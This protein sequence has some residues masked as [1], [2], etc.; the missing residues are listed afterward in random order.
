MIC[1]KNF[2]FL[3]RSQIALTARRRRAKRFGMED[4]MTYEETTEKIIK[5]LK[6]YKDFFSTEYFLDFERKATN[7]KENIEESLKEGR[8][9]KIGIVG[10][11][12]AGK[13]SFL[14]SMI[15]DGE[16]ILPK[17][18]TPMTAALT[19]IYYADK[20]TAKIVFY[21][22]KD[23]ERVKSYSDE[24]LKI[25][26]EEYE[27]YREDL[28][29]KKPD[30][31]PVTKQQYKNNCEMIPDQYKS[32]NELV[33]MAK[34]SNIMIE[35]W[36]GK[37]KEVDC[38]N[39]S[40]ELDDYIG[41]DG[42]YTAIVKYV[43][44]G[45]DNDALKGL[46]IVDTPGMNDP[47]ISRGE[48]TRQFLQKCDV[49]F[50]LSYT[51]QF[52]TQ[53]DINFM[54]ETLPREGVN[55]LLIVGSKLD[56]GVIDNSKD[57]DFITA[58]RKS[59]KIYNSQAEAHIEKSIRNEYN[60]EIL[61]K[62]KE[63]LPPSYVSSLVYDVAR[64]RSKGI[65][66]SKNEQRII[67]LFKKRFDGFSEEERFLLSFSGIPQ[68]R[69]K[70]LGEI[71]KHKDQ[72]IEE[73]NSDIV[74][75]SRKQLCGIIEQIKNEVDTNY[76]KLEN[77][78]INQL[79]R[80]LQS[81]KSALSD[82]R[83]YIENVFE[84]Y[85][86][87]AKKILNNMKVDI[88]QE[89]GNYREFNIKRE[90]EQDYD[91][92]KTGFIFKKKQ[93]IQTSRTV[94]SANITDVIQNLRNYII[95]CKKLVNETFDKAVNINQLK[96]DIKDVIFNV[97]EKTGKDFNEADVLI[98]LDIVLGRILIPKLEIEV[99]EYEGMIIDS[100]SGTSVSGEKVEQL[101]RQEDRVLDQISGNIKRQ[102]DEC[103]SK[104]CDIMKEQSTVFVDNV[105]KTL[106]ENIN[107]LKRQLSDRKNN[108][109]RYRELQD[110]LLEYYTE[111][112]KM[113]I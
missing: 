67:D 33:E 87:D 2:S 113:E 77:G 58:V 47:I 52:L 3:E 51:G 46:E 26:D 70:K 106:E 92:V 43:E 66:L 21:N 102:I 45:M 4:F 6:Q 28:K 35:E 91:V 12:K 86:V 62:I 25:L 90:V 42:N 98:T 44:L 110:Y 50:L 83:R 96:R 63:S 97:F 48:I 59:K 108:L 38:S 61:Q 24:C 13:S 75:N 81:I 95:R 17:A 68:V 69:V 79:E 39:F 11:M 103:E 37:E 72:W 31:S 40:D 34:K 8:L 93:V 56:S 85:M 32:C 49:V 104:V 1:K 99:T 54:T 36:L 14:N 20:N 7:L 60:G 10:E 82:M 64:K 101:K 100:F 29:E 74:K 94:Y 107:L 71:R 27:K 30:M 109:C 111:I 15:F 65:S 112:D 18:S 88:D 9:L 76:S 105:V 23:W 80:Q 73:K 57:K 19:K 5:G 89:I 22:E 78:D 55:N 53:E 84:K 41:V 16:D